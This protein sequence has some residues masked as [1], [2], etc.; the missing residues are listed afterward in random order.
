[1]SRLT[2]TFDDGR[3]FKKSVTPRSKTVWI[4]DALSQL[5][6]QALTDAPNLEKF[7]V[8]HGRLENLGA[9]QTCVRLRE[10]SL[11][12]HPGV[13]M[14][15]CKALPELSELSIRFEGDAAPDLSFLHG[16]SSLKRLHLAYDRQQGCD[17][18]PLRALSQLEHLT[19]FGK[20]LWVDLAPLQ[21][22]PVRQLSLGLGGLANIVEM[23]WHVL[24]ATTQVLAVYFPGLD[25]LA[26]DGLDSLDRLKVLNLERND[27]RWMDFGGLREMT[28][29]TRI[30]L[31][32]VKNLYGLDD[33]TDYGDITSPAVREL[34]ALLS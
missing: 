19:L 9:L 11:P 6:C 22:L 13:Q 24:P 15:P 3:S 14:V 7:S 26:F 18:E 4:T 27:L 17:L 12:L 1:M 16:A 5:D 21:G 28:S 32:D 31:P 33:D 23:P 29:L 20:Q 2:G 8:L 10:V 34:V 25:S 30:I